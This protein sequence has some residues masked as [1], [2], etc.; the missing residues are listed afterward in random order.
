MIPARVCH[1]AQPLL[2]TRAL[3][4]VHHNSAGR[5]STQQ[6]ADEGQDHEQGFG[7]RCEGQPGQAF[8]KG[9]HQVGGEVTGRTRGVRKQVPNLP[10]PPQPALQPPDHGAGH[11]QHSRGG[12]EEVG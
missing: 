8:G 5:V 6:V 10:P 12:K 7:R 9:S 1:H 4:A 3:W 11:P 2:L